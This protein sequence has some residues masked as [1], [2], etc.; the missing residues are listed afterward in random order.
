MVATN[1]SM[2]LGPWVEGVNLALPPEN[3]NKTAIANGQNIEVGL[4]GVCKTRAGNTKYISSALSGDPTLTAT[5][6][7]EFSLSSAAKFCVAGTAW[8][9]DMSGTWTARTGSAT[10]TAADD[11]TWSWVMANGDLFATSNSLADVP[12]KWAAAGGTN[13]TAAGLSSR[14]TKAAWL[15]W[16]D[17]RLWYGQT[18]SNE[19]RAY[20]SD[21]LTPETIGATSF[22]NFGTPITGLKGL[23]T[24]LTVHSEDAIFIVYYDNALT[25]YVQQ[26]RA[27]KGTVAGRSIVVN[28]QG[29]MFFLRKDGVYQWDIDSPVSTE[30]SG[31][32]TKISVPLDG[33]RYWDSVNQSRMHQAFAI[34]YQAKNCI[35]FV[36]PYGTSQT[37]MN[38]ILVYDYAQKIWY[39]PYTGV[40]RN[41]GAFFDD[42]PH[43]G[44]YDNGLLFK[45]DDGTSD[46]GVAI[47]AFFETAAAAAIDPAVEVRWL[48]AKTAFDITGAHEIY[49]QQKA[50]SVVARTESFSG[51]QT[52]AAIGSFVIGT[53]TISGDNLLRTEQTPLQGYS[54]SLQLKYF[55]DTLDQKMSIRNVRVPFRP[56][57]IISQSRS[58]VQ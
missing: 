7:A 58:G 19:E 46:N 26:Q 30:M 29:Q 2:A 13:V 9:E 22:L 11:N 34:D 5:G 14:F 44:G 6:E 43:L 10:I 37:D 17:N 8:Y 3:V 12:L 42:F 20:Y 18:N 25:K 31:M 50:D 36:I 32:P 23:R 51:G 48:N 16:W 49:V 45:S 24:V 1:Q 4:G 52:Y 21:I 40:T 57:G 33:P 53:S 15:E 27:D 56:I 54:D 38:H 39:P 47:N 41:C 35:W 28:A 55:N